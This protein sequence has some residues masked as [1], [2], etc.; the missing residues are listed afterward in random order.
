MNGWARS[1]PSAFRGC[2]VLVLEDEYLI[3]E[4]I[5]AELEQAGA[6]TIGPVARIHEALDLVR[7]SGRIDA[8]LLDVNLGSEAAWPVVDALLARHVPLLLATGYDASAIPAAYAALPRCEKPI[9]GRDIL[10]ALARLLAP[11][12]AM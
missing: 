8:A 2:R 5:A 12:A 3:A 4:E 1:E 10:R 6:E 9:S 7:G 11:T